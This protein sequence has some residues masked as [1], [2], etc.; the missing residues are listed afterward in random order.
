MLKEFDR[1]VNLAYKVTQGAQEALSCER[2]SHQEKHLPLW[3]TAFASSL[4]SIGLSVH[5]YL[6]EIEAINEGPP[7]FTRCVRDELLFQHFLEGET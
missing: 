7:D 4:T 5:Y 1:S 6:V 3:A 2:A